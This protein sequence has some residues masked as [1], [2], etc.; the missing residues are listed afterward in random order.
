MKLREYQETAI[1]KL[2]AAYLRGLRSLCLVL[3]TGGG[4]TIVAAAIILYAIARGTR[5]LFVADRCTL[6]DQTV[7]KLRFAGVIDVR[8]IQA[9][10]D[11]GSPAALVTVASA[12]TLR[13]PGWEHRLPE[14]DLVIWDE[15]HGVAASTYSDTLKRYARAK[16]LGLTA[17]PY[18]GDNKPLGMFAELVIGATM[19]QLT[20][21]GHLAPLHV[22]RPQAELGSREIAMDPVAAYMQHAAGKR[23]AVF[24]GRVADANR[25]CAAFVAAGVP[26]EVVTA[27]TPRR[28]DVI[29][30]FA[31]DAFRVLL[32][33]GTLTQ[34]WDDPGCEVAILE[35]KPKHAGLWIQICGRVARPH[36]GKREG[37]VI[38]LPGAIFDHGH[39][40][41]D[42]EYSLTGK[43]IS[44]VAKDS[45]RHCSKCGSIA[46]AG[47]AACPYC[48][49]EYPV[50]PQAAQRVV[51]VGL[52]DSTS[53]PA[54]RREYVVSMVSK[55]HGT[56]ARCG[57]G[58][59]SGDPIFW[60]TVAKQARHQ[61][62]PATAQIGA[63]S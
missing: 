63:Q 60:A 30:R 54:P 22:L 7:A 3:P 56:C 2:R 58:I 42:R 44:A 55:R 32:S 41:A 38:D 16:I 52:V 4:K 17:T 13:M 18:R 33:V 28:A 46:V 61:Q 40:A 27:S 35:R 49:T 12:Q 59:R 36:P 51:G 14:A 21:L 5:V 15:C 37:L 25:L 6:I 62:C 48:G 31:D 9:D 23:A 50:R 43:A 11:D 34:G 26:A 1:D 20:D 24:C 10:R 29:R 53:V 57:R 47:P 8:V 39:P 45:V 19:R